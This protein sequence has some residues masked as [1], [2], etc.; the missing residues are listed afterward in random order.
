MNLGSRKS[1]F[2]ER[3]G[4][5]GV[6]DDLRRGVGPGVR[7]AVVVREGPGVCPLVPW[8]VPCDPVCIIAAI[9]WRRGHVAPLDGLVCRA[10]RTPDRVVQGVGIPAAVCARAIGAIKRSQRRPFG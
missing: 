10:N 5:E 1:G 9:G 7:H 2:N 6:G 3:E 4:C 8:Q